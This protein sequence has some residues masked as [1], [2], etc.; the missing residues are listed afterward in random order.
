MADCDLA[1][2]SVRTRSS[3]AEH[4]PTDGPVNELHDRVAKVAERLSISSC[5]VE[6][7][8][9]NLFFPAYIL[10]AELAKPPNTRGEILV[11]RRSKGSPTPEKAL[12]LDAENQVQGRPVVAEKLR[13]P[14][15]SDD[16]VVGKDVFHWEDLCYDIEIKGGNRRLLDHVDGWVKPGVS[17]ILM[18]VP[19]AGKTT[20]LDVL[21]TR[22]T[23]GDVTGSTMVN[24]NPTDPSFQ[25]KVG[26]VQQQDLHLSIMTVHEA[27]RFSVILRQSAE[28]T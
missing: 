28:M 9:Q 13:S 1:N 3:A 7:Q 25:H 5:S 22:V 20:L 6:W 4:T 10:A 23:T 24:G 19:G 12:S 26:Y 15:G 11:S 8:S 18:G 17:T 27:L 2:T 14:S 21:A 16:R